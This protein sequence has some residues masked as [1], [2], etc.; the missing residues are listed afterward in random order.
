MK[1][2]QRVLLL[3]LIF[4]SIY[5]PKCFAGEKI[6][7][8]VYTNWPC[9]IANTNIAK[10]VLEKTMGYKVHIEQ[11]STKDMWK[12]IASGKADATVSAW[13]PTFH[14]NHLKKYKSKVKILNPVSMGVKSG[15][16]VP[17]YVT[18][19]S[20]SNLKSKAHKFNKHILCLNKGSGLCSIAQKAISNY[21]LKGFTIKEVK[22]S[23]ISDLIKK[24]QWFLLSLFEP[25][26]LTSEWKYKYLDDPKKIFPL[27]EKIIA[28]IRNGFEKEE[29]DVYAFLNRFYWSPKDIQKLLIKN[30]K[31]PSLNYKNTKD[32]ISKNHKQLNIWLKDVKL[33][34][35]KRKFGLQ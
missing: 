5:L 2:Y 34:H 9:S 3:L 29:P 28:V 21:G 31:N 33:G 13:L 1:K 17:T 7:N 23:E 12:S 8:L 18:I 20:I 11:K 15:I 26:W 24:K 35:T 30:H 16:I 6:I 14:A 27:E 4:F 19:N 22:A 10:A 32:Y 25:H